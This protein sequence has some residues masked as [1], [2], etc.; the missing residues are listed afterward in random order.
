MLE[1]SSKEQYKDQVLTSQVIDHLQKNNFD[2]YKIIYKTNCL[3]K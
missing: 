1:L 2:P 3:L